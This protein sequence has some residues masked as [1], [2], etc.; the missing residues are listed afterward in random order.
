[1]NLQLFV[2]LV[3]IRA[4]LLGVALL[5]LP[6]MLGLYVIRQYQTA[7]GIPKAR[8]LSRTLLLLFVAAWLAFIYHIL[9]TYD[10]LVGFPELLEDQTYLEAFP[11]HLTQHQREDFFT[12]LTVSRRMS[13]IAIHTVL[14]VFIFSV[15]YW[16]AR[17]QQQEPTESRY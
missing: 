1:M 9:A 8:A 11:D 4:Y 3:A 13:L 17:R 14:N 5:F 10:S 15:R 12:A 2:G 16:M 7:E 6:L